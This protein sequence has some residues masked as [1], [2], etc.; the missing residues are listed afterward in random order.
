MGSGGLDLD[1]ISIWAEKEKSQSR[2]KQLSER[3]HLPVFHSRPETPLCLYVDKDKLGLG[4]SKEIPFRP[5]YV[6]FC[7]PQW[8]FRRRKGLSANRLFLTATGIKEGTR[9]GDL[10]AGFGQDAF[11]MAWAG[12]KVTAI[13]QSAVVYEVLLDGLRRAFDGDS[14]WTH[15][16]RLQAICTDSLSFLSTTKEKFDVLYL[17][18]MFEKPKKKAKSPKP[19]QLLQTLFA[20]NAPSI[21]EL[22]EAAKKRALSR[23]VVKLPLKGELPL[24]KPN[25]TFAGQSIRYDVYLLGGKE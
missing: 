3:L 20:P 18:P 8:W 11:V 17:D 14:Q 23:V 16:E 12:A 21:V 7:S 13:E 19:M 4:F 10:T 25:V 9:V 1:V 5:Y 6:D 22:F 24:L 2:A 15:G